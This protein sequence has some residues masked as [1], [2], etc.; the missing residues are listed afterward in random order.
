MT[1][2]YLEIFNN[3]AYLKNQ[4]LTIT[5]KNDENIEDW[6]NN[7]LSIS[8]KKNLK[9]LVIN[10]FY[11]INPYIKCLYLTDSFSLAIAKKIKFLSDLNIKYYKQF[12]FENDFNSDIFDCYLIIGSKPGYLSEDAIN[13]VKLLNK[14]IKKDKQIIFCGNE[15]L[16]NHITQSK[17]TTIISYP[18]QEFNKI[19]LI[20]FANQFT[21]KFLTLYDIKLKD[22][23]FKHKKLKDI[24]V[25]F[26]S[27]NDL[28][29][30]I[31]KTKIYVSFNNNGCKIYT[32][33]KSEKILTNAFPFLKPENKDFLC[34]WFKKYEKKSEF[35]NLINPY[36]KESTYLNILDGEADISIMFWVNILCF[37]DMIKHKS[38][39][40]NELKIE[41]LDYSNNDLFNKFL[42]F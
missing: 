2:N 34:E 40:I 24:E 10:A 32:K 16:L 39:N 13:Y 6:L 38:L 17:K 23:I 42:K 41:N 29:K 21:T 11:P 5:R 14:K 20:D 4:N 3:T 35:L 19:E 30:N 15:E 22:F 33:N 18:L 26:R 12:T 27:T 8:F 9:K 25:T 36:S 7:I 1:I 31:Q 28:K 37:L